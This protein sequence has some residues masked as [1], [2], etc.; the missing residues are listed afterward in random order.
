MK[1]DILTKWNID[2]IEGNMHVEELRDDYD[3]KTILLKGEKEK[4]PI[5]KILFEDT[6][7][8]RNT[9]ESYMLKVWHNTP[10][11]MLGKVFYRILKSSYI[12][13]F[14]EMTLNLYKDWNIIHFAI[15]TNK[16]CIDILAQIPPKI[17][18]INDE[19]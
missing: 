3:G 18:W 12:D 9:D 1:K 7:S 10:K 4:T 19:N 11:A 8:Y 17:E 13:F 5:L 2:N 14:N 16:D 6:L 15:Y